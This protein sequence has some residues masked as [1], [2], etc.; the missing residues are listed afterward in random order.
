[1]SRRAL[2]AGMALLSLA[3]AA[4]YWGWQR[5]EPLPPPGAS[6]SLPPRIIGFRLRVER[7]GENA[8]TF[9]RAEL[10]AALRDPYQLTYLG[11]IAAA[12]DGSGVEIVAAPLGSLTQRLGLQPGDVIRSINGEAVATPRDLA[13]I[14]AKDYALPGI[15]GQVQRGARTLTFSYRVRG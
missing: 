10:E 5:L 4:T 6:E 15:E 3:A 13:R 14:Y 8:F 9:A 7:S 12:H 2:L 1:V 11:R